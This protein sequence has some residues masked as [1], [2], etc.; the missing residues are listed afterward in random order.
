[1]FSILGE[2]KGFALV[3]LLTVVVIIAILGAVVAPNLFRAVDK[4]RV[5]AAVADSRNIKGAAL[6]YYSDTGLWPADSPGGGDPGFLDDPGVAGW[7]GPY[8]ESWPGKN[9]WG[10][11]YA[12]VHQDSQLFGV[13]A[14]CL[15]MSSVPGSTAEK[16]A[17]Q[18]GSNNVRESSGYVYIL[19][20]KD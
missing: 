16:L 13:A 2:K 15:R 12:F 19:L 14:K 9:P 7:N 1:M 5:T 6:A 8:L 20:A 4:S 17:E 18:L 3:E 11:T 10:G